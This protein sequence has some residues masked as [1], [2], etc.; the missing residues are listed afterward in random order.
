MF[1]P[2]GDKLEMIFGQA[3]AHAAAT[4]VEDDVPLGIVVPTDDRSTAEQPAQATTG[5][6]PEEPMR[7]ERRPEPAT[8][9]ATR[10]PG[11][12]LYVPFCE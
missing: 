9:A 11:S 7:A 10:V 6:A 3:T 12:A 4:R 1:S 5:A 8:V 2:S